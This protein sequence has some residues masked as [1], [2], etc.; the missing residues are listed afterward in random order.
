MSN[1]INSEF[2]QKYFPTLRD[3]IYL[4]NA[5]TGIPPIT[6]INAMKQYLEN[7]IR[8]KG[9]LEES[10]KLLKSV[11]DLLAKLLGGKRRNYGFTASTSGGINAFAHGISYPENSNIIIC[12]LEFPS[13]YIP[14]QN[15]SRLY[16]VEF[17]VVKSEEGSVSLNSFRE[18]CDENTRVVAI[19]HTQFSS[20]FRVNLNALSDMVHDVGGYLVADIIQAA[21]WIDVDYTKAGVDFAA[22]QAAKWL[23]GPIGAGFV[24]ISD[25]IMNQI[26]PRFLS[27][28]GCK[29]LVNFEYVEKEPYD[30]ARKIQLG[31]PFP[32]AYVGFEQSLKLLCGMSS[33]TRE[34]LSL[35]NANYLRKRLSEIGIEYYDFGPKHN[36]PIVSCKPKNVEE[37]NE[38]LSKNHIH[39]SV[40]NGRLRVSPHFYNTYEEIDKL[41]DRFG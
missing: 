35:D 37:L 13:N 17:R 10:L 41:I 6:S 9:S 40:R 30:D 22:G 25:D 1:S 21:G 5:G 4:N 14:W 7:R 31:S 26:T 23:I 11:R 24:Y 19:S 39:C 36:S 20:G 28:W 33:S 29:D 38:E 15:V 8:A 18:K 32:I 27:W 12:D 3:M 16:N 34:K 2:I